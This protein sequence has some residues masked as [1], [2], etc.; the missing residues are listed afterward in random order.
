[1]KMK[2][3][4]L[5]H[6]IKTSNRVME[7]NREFKFRAWVDGRMGTP[8]NAF[9][10]E[11]MSTGGTFP[12]GTIIMQFTGLKDKEGREIYEGDFIKSSG[13]DI[14]LVVW[15]QDLASFALRKDGW[16]YDHYF[17]EAVDAGHTQVI[18]NFYE[19]PE[20]IDKSSITEK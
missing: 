15:R 16:L 8:F 18:G 12:D 14:M 7:K 1:M 5:P 11:F 4:P 10:P 3:K 20:L 9:D 19:N 17:G 6:L 2:I 13:G